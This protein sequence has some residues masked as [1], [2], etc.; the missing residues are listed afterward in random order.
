MT[1]RKDVLTASR[2]DL[3]LSLLPII[4]HPEAACGLADSGVPLE[5]AARVLAT[6]AERHTGTTAGLFNRSQRISPLVRYSKNENLIN[7]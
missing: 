5:V 1:K 2:V 3:V 7:M 6:P 4:S